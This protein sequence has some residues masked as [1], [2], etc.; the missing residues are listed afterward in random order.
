[1]LPARYRGGCLENPFRRRTLPQQYVRTLTW[2][3]AAARL[4]TLYSGQAEEWTV[5]I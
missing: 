1:M 5:R 3:Q 4:R 2:W